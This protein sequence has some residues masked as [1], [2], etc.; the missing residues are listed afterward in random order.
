MINLRTERIKLKDWLSGN[1]PYK[2]CIYN[3][4]GSCT[5]DDGEFIEDILDIV[6]K[7]VIDKDSN[8][9][10]ECSAIEVPDDVCEFCN[11]E[12]SKTTE[13]FP[14]GDTNVPYTFYECTNKNC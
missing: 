1:C 8:V 3:T 10:F 2:G 6:D 7:N 5:Y 9:Y 14:Y 12:L 4:D 11:H 13:Q